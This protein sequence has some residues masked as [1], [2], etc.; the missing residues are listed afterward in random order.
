M[1]FPITNANSADFFGF[2]SR[3]AIHIVSSYASAKNRS[4]VLSLDVLKLLYPNRYLTFHF[5]NYFASPGSTSLSQCCPFLVE[6]PIRSN[7]KL[8]SLRAQSNGLEY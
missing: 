7:S 8:N 4:S 5:K 3:K 2:E 1:H 6:M